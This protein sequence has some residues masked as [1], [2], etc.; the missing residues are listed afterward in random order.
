M[1]IVQFFV[2]FCFAEVR[3]LVGERSFCVAA[4]VWFYRACFLVL[5]DLRLYLNV[6]KQTNTD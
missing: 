4:L 6:H 2:L 1:G 5:Y 3:V